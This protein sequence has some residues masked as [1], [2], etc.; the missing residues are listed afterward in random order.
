MKTW[1]HSCGVALCATSATLVAQSAHAEG[2]PRYT[3]QH[4]KVVIDDGSRREEVVV[5]CKDTFALLEHDQ[6]LYLACGAEGVVVYSLT[7]PF[8]PMLVGQIAASDG[9]CVGLAADGTC[10]VAPPMPVT[11]PDI[12]DDPMTV[13]V[14]VDGPGARLV[15][16]AKI[17]AK[18]QVPP[19]TVCVAPCDV[20][21]PRDGRFVVAEPN[22]RRSKSFSLPSTGAQERL[23]VGQAMESNAVLGAIVLSTTLP[24]A[25]AFGAAAFALP[26]HT[27]SCSGG[28]GS[29]GCDATT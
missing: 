15:R 28:F 22:R 26:S 20:R 9:S 3:L 6:R 7:E 18:R 13:L 24:I 2:K 29:P 19:V 12:V 21:V 17:H 1:I 27:S 5:D 25:A 23:V 8:R 11:Q 16:Y 10:V 4:D 14:H